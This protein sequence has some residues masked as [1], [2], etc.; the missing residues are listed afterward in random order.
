MSERNHNHD[1][2]EPE[3][4]DDL[5]EELCAFLLGELDG[6]AAAKV[7]AALA[8]SAEL[9]DE[10]DRIEATIGLVRSACGVGGACGGDGGESLSP[11]LLGTIEQAARPAPAP[12]AWYRA[13]PFRLA[14]GFAALAGG[15]IAGKALLTEP[16][17]PEDVLV[18]R[19]EQEIA[20][21]GTELSLKEAFRLQKDFDVEVAQGAAVGSVEALDENEEATLG[22]PMAERGGLQERTRGYLRAEADPSGATQGPHKPY[23]GHIGPSPPSD[24][25]GKA[26]AELYASPGGGGGGG[27]VK[28][29]SEELD[30]AGVPVR[31]VDGRASSTGGYQGPRDS[32]SPRGAAPARS[33]GNK[34]AGEPSTGFLYDE[35]K[36]GRDKGSSVTAG[37]A[38]LESLGYTA[39]AEG[40]AA[41]GEDV[42]GRRENLLQGA[43][44]ESEKSKGTADRT[45]EDLL[46]R[47]RKKAEV[48]AR[49]S[50]PASP[51]PAG[52]VAPPPAES[53]DRY[54]LHYPPD[55]SDAA[56]VRKSLEALGYISGD[57]DDDALVDFETQS[58]TFHL[59]RGT[60]SRESRD[61]SR[62]QLRRELTPAEIDELCRYRVERIL[63]GCRRHPHEK[64][65]MMF[66]RFWGDNPFV[67]AQIDNQSTFGVDVDTASYALARRY[68]TEGHLPQKAQ[69]RTEEFVNYFKP[70][71]PAP[72]EENF[73]IH[74]DL[75]PSRFGGNEGVNNQRW[76]MRVVVRGREVPATE[77]T[78][79]NLT[80][81][82]D[83]SGSMKEN[84]RLELV[85]H[86]LRLLT[87]QLD[88]NDSIAIVAFSNEARMVLPMTSM[89]NRGVVEAAIFGMQPNGGTNAEGGLRLG[90]E[91]ATAALAP[92]LTHRVVLLSDGVA[93]I[94]QTDQNRINTDVKRNRDLGIYLNTIGVGMNNHNDVFLEQLANKGDGL[95]N[96]IDSAI[97]AKRALVDNFTGA[98]EPIARDVKIQVEF[99]KTQVYHHRLLGYENRAIADQDFRNDAID[100]G[101]IGSG[102]QVVA[103]YELE[104]TGIESS[105][106][107]ATVRLRWK[108]PIGVGRDP[109]EDTA[110]EIAHPVSFASA[111]SWEGA[112]GGYQ[113]SVLVAQFAEILRR[114]VHARGDSLD[115]LIAESAKLDATLADPDF[116]EF[117]ALLQKSRELI[118]RHIPHHDD[119][120]LCIDAIRRN[121]ILH[122]QYEEL[123]RDEKRAVIDEL[124]RQNAQLEAR[125]RELIRDEIRGEVR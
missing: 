59:K 124:E 27:A 21:E 82:V 89:A 66:F 97:E 15:V 64:P 115:V 114:S 1:V 119:L 39:E 90:Y 102:H 20:H 60:W 95:C 14:A 118:L 117:V 52:T 88:V 112:S 9:R 47:A 50:A 123:R 93:N 40:A 99:D 84:D 55:G 17:A 81:V 16:P 100:A 61:R 63:Q 76:M 96:Y 92:G 70:D 41:A 49:P 106:P 48:A 30:S 109:L 110:T 45:A 26:S 122:A 23:G 7:E 46:R 77:R 108:Q 74:T 65:S 57:S 32:V 6:P 37:L 10:R 68:L 103:L 43:G 28:L 85:K 113:R 87:T 12:R 11:E 44:V 36:E 120:T 98:I 107:M 125:I 42:R 67:L 101:E 5:H 34:A 86:A 13:T 4:S 121:R 104:M 25:K 38:Q 51:G 62:A 53:L 33:S 2:N 22:R 75:A 29:A 72:L 58:G 69:I 56:E 24:A 80:F 73:A 8:D 94:G 78:P 3:R 18:A 35:L 105:E 19:L 71:V 83:T 116:T 54:Y 31:I 91:V 111:G 79:V